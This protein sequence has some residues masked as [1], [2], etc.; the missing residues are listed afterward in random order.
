MKKKG[1]TAGQLA[2]KAR[3]DRVLYDSLEVGYDISQTEIIKGLEKTI[4]THNKIFDE[5]EYCVCY[6]IAKDSILVNVIRLKFYAYLYLPSPRPDQTVFLYS[7]KAD[8]ITKRL[9]T[10]PNAITMEA[11]Y[12]N[13]TV[14]E[15]YKLM[16]AWT[17]AFYDGCFWQWIRKQH[18]IKMLSE[19][20]FLQVHRKELIKSAPEQ[21]EA[22]VSNPLD[23]AQVAAEKIINPHAF[24]PE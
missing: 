21:V 3:Q 12:M 9:W 5:T 10:L 19:S 22:P 14:P 15:S 7:K 24:V 2:L 13:H 1:E 18:D 16:K 8:R 11:L 6:V 4:D 20:E 23:H 17:H